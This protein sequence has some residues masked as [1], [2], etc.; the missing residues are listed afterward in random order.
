MKTLSSF[1]L[2]KYLLQHE[3]KAR[4]SLCNSGLDGLNLR[5]ILAVSTE[6]TQ[7][8]WERQSLGYSEPLGHPQ[9]RQE[10][11]RLYAG[12][13]PEHVTIFAGAAE[14]IYCGLHAL[15]SPEDHCIV[16]TPCYQSLKSVPESVCEVSTVSLQPVERQ[17]R[18]DTHAIRQ[19]IRP[20]TTALIL[21]FPN[22]P[23]GALPEHTVLDELVILARE[24]NLYL[25]SDEVYRGLELP[26]VEAWPAMADIYEKGVSVGS[27]SKLYGMP[28]T[29]VG[30]LACPDENLMSRVV[31]RRHYTTICNNGAGELL[32]LMALQ[33]RDKLLPRNKAVL[34]PQYAILRDFLERHDDL[35]DW[36]DPQAGCLVF[37]RLKRGLKAERFALDLLHE[38]GV[39]ILPGQ[40][41]E[42]PGEYIR[43]GYAGKTLPQALERFE[44][45]I[46]KA[47]LIA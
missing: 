46:A 3:H 12:L 22:N 20:N 2:E 38:T 7:A 14:A 15:L 10:V 26:G 32:A 47:R 27:L 39:L 13:E 45:F 30:W 1:V 31:G 42:F 5:D 41:Y 16:V 24:F 6:A 11:S 4:L 23:T 28:G 17:W 33:G 34:L 29:R 40:V 21:N 37:P 36:I 18:L 9:L 35:F 8:L 19:A 43:L 44:S 25:F